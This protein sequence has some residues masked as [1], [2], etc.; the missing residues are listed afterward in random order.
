MEVPRQPLR[1]AAAEPVD[2]SE[3]PKRTFLELLQPPG[4]ST[5]QRRRLSASSTEMPA[6]S[7]TSDAVAS[8]WTWSMVFH[9]DTEPGQ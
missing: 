2:E 6:A 3:K 8:R 7:A 5:G 4:G 9:I 1:W